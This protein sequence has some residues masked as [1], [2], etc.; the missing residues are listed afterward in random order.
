[1]T[2]EVLSLGA[3]AM[4]SKLPANIYVPSSARAL[5]SQLQAD[6][7]TIETP[8]DEGYEELKE[9][10]RPSIPQ[11]EK[12]DGASTA[13]QQKIGASEKRTATARASFENR[14]Q[15]LQLEMSTQQQ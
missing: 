2:A 5:C 9:Q 12:L 10:M 3:L 14:L 4:A 6:L 13:L 1:M 8:S 7:A 15:Q 11:L